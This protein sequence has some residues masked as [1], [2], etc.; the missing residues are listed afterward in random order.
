MAAKWKGREARGNVYALLE[1]KDLS[2]KR[3][4]QMTT[5]V[6][7]NPSGYEAVTQGLQ[8]VLRDFYLPSHSPAMGLSVDEPN[9]AEISDPPLEF[10][11]RR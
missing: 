11:F 5:S 3:A 1:I 9:V 4:P 2:V 8:T 7:R 6:L 10:E